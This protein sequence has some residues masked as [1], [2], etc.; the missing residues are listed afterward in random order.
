MFRTDA[1]YSMLVI[2]TLIPLAGGC[3]RSDQPRTTSAGATPTVSAA[4]PASAGA[5]TPAAVTTATYENA[6]SIFRAGAYPEAAE[7]FTAYSAAHP[8]NPWGHYMLGMSNWKTGEQEKALTAFDQALKLDPT[9]RKS[10]FNSSRVLLEGGR[11]KEALERIEKALGQEPMSNEGLRLL[12]RVRY[13]LGDVE[14]AIGAYRR[15]LSLDERD[16]WSMNNLGLIYIQ[17]DRSSEALAPLARA[18]ELRSNAPVFQNNLGT[19]L[20]RSG[21]PTAAAEAYEAAIAVDSTYQKASVGL[22]RVTSG[23]QKLES[24]PVDLAALSSQFQATIDTWRGAE[25]GDSI[26]VTVARVSDS[27]SVPAETVSDSVLVSGKIVSDSLE[28]CESEE[29]H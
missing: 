26:A 23:E 11:P 22:A 3:G 29:D 19:A 28:E 12:G 15:A 17:Q 24:T 2:A 21:Y 9:H 13:E 1:R 14:G 25:V 18:V 20:E 7:L 6:E 16:V 4:S 8:E 27:N 5:E 10:L